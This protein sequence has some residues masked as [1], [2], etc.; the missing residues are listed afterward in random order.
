EDIAQADL[1]SAYTFLRQ[2][3]TIDPTKIILGGVSQGTSLMLNAV[4]SRG[5]SV[6]GLV[7]VI[8]SAP[9]FISRYKETDPFQQDSLIC[10]TIVGENDPRY[11]KTLEIMDFLEKKGV[12]TKLLSDPELGHQY[13]K[14]FNELLIQAI[15]F[16][17]IHK[18]PD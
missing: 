6:Q 14:N 10:C 16:I 13:P 5:I 9:N 1:I 17:L 7:P 18:S 11:Q 8:P 12:K 2:N 15:D 4:F 3:F